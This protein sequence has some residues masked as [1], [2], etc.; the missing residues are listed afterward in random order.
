MPIKE[1]LK[2]I[3]DLFLCF[4]KIGAF[5]FGGGYAMVSLVQRDMVEKKK[6]LTEREMVDVIAIAVGF[7]FRVDRRDA[8][9]CYYNTCDLSR[10]TAFRRKPIC[11]MGFF[12]HTRL[13]IG[14]YTER[15]V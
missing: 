2:K 14:S 4:L 3:L 6:W 5:T 15:N 10:H 12:G 13:R 8:A 1:R 11:Q 9:V 7:A